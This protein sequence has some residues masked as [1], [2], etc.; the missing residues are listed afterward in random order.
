MESGCFLTS[1]KTMSVKKQTQFVCVQ[2]WEE[3]PQEIKTLS[4]YNF[5]KQ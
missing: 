2:I 1:V 4:F 5:K 3:I